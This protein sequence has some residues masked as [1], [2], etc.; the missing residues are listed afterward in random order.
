MRGARL[1]GADIGVQL[2][3][4]VGQRVIGADDE[5]GFV[6]GE[7]RQAVLLAGIGFRAER[8]GG[9]DKL[10]GRQGANHTVALWLRLANWAGFASGEVK[11]GAAP[12]CLGVDAASPQ[13]RLT[14]FKTGSGSPCA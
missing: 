6:L 1:P 9:H 5:I 4:G 11:R 10:L 7:V 8:G 2:D 13:N 3:Q 14:R 12:L